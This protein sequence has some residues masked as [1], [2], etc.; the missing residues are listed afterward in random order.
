MYTP[1]PILTKYRKYMRAEQLAY[2]TRQQYASMLKQFLQAHRCTP[3]RITTA[4][5]ISYLAAIP[6]PVTRKQARAAIGKLYA[7]LGHSQKMKGVPK[8]LQPKSLP[9]YLTESEVQRLLSVISNVKHRALLTLIYE[10]A[11]RISELQNLRILDIKGKEALLLIH[12]SK[13][14]KDRQVPV[15]PYVIDLLRKYYRSYRP[16]FFLF[17]G[18]P[19][20]RYSK[21]SIRAIL[22]N[23]LRKAG[24]QSTITPHGL[25]HS[26]ATHLLNAGVDIKHIK[27]LL[28][29]TRIATTENYL[30]L[31]T[32]TLASAVCAV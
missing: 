11:L 9:A 21:S 12:H 19:G 28:G 1:E 2:S 16:A 26:R 23:A 30:H 17:E 7:M 24:I 20:T 8:P 10:G 3:E 27:E 32:A 6:S 15:K 25:R 14:A 4:H 13:G 22:K 5:I 29:H 31:S 18:S